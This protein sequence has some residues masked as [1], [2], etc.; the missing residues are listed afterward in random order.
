[1]KYISRE[2]FRVFDSV[3]AKTRTV[4]PFTKYFSNCFLNNIQMFFI[5]RK[6]TDGQYRATKFENKMYQ[7][8]E[9]YHFDGKV[10]VLV[11]GG[12]FSASCLFL[13]NIK[14]QKGITI[15]GEETGGSSYGNTGI[16]LPGLEL[17]KTK[18]RVQIPLYRVIHYRHPEK[19]GRGIVPDIIVPQD[20]DALLEGR[21]KKMEVVKKIILSQDN[22]RPTI[23]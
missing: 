17:P 3:Y 8:K 7:I 11:S 20:Y 1:T 6:K 15:I 22:Q 10:Y 16:L 21:D 12:T 9:K 18:L 23:E 13:N 5:A 4:A 19:N 14:G 2:P